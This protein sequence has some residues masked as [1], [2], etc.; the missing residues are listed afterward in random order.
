MEMNDIELYL[1]SQ[2]TSSVLDEIADDLT[3]TSDDIQE[4]NFLINNLK[5]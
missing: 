5:T 3:I 4:L 2:L 1:L